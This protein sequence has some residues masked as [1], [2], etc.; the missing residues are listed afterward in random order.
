[1]RLGE[2]CRGEFCCIRRREVT[3]PAR[4]LQPPDDCHALPRNFRYRTGTRTNRPKSPKA[5]RT[6]GE[7]TSL[8]KLIE[9]NSRPAFAKT[10][11]PGMIPRAVAATYVPSLIRVR[12]DRRLTKK[13]G[14]SG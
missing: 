12:P 14:K 9:P 2:R 13:N 7:A 1:M 10:K 8:R 6:E 5:P 11:V 4:S 3:S